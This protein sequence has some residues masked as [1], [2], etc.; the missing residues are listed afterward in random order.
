MPVPWDPAKPYKG[1]GFRSVDA[2]VKETMYGLTEYG[3]KGEK[4]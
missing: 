2:K 3:V 1:L 4:L